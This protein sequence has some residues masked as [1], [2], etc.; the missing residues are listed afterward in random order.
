MA[1]EKGYLGTKFYNNKRL[2]FKQSF[3]YQYKHFRASN[4]M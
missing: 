3:K 1:K 4:L 2:T